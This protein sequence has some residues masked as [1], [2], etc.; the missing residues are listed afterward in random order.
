MNVRHAENRMN[1]LLPRVL[2]IGCATASLAAQ[3]FADMV[4]Q[5][6]SAQ[7]FAKI[8]QLEAGAI[9]TEPNDREESTGLDR[10]VSWDARVWY[11]NESFGSRRGTLEA[12][13]GRDGLFAGFQ[14][15]KLIGD[16]TVTRFE[17][18]GRPWVFYRDAY[19]NDDDQLVPNGLYDG[20]DWEGYIGFGKEAQQ[21]LLIE[22]GPYYRKHEFQRSG[23]TPSPAQF[24]VPN[25]FNAYGLRMYFEQSTLQFD[26]RRGSVREGYV[27]SLCGERE[28][29]DSKGEFGSAAFTTELPSAVWRLR[30]RLD[31]YIPATETICWE[32]FASGGWHDE[33]DRLQNTDGSRP[34]GN[35]W[36]D[37][38]VRLRFDLG[39]S[40]SLAPFV[41]GQ[42]SRTLSLDGFSS[43]KNLFYGGG[44][45]F[46]LHLAD[47]LSLHG[48]YSYLDNENRPS[49]RIDQDLRGEH[50]FYLG[51]VLR[52]GMTRR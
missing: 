30:G 26:R 40:F 9:G 44:A 14:D 2:V 8:L 31:W 10:D 28:W 19:Y 33:K 52:L 38:Q 25:D 27:L 7:P 1:H 29:N 51:M 34:L 49:I 37:V 39:Q 4:E 35:Q 11:R 42:F 13:A 41:Q 23:L 15:G 3:S 18:R 47:P 32:V 43:N 24:T 17:F 22:L 21:G 5:R 20:R 45:E 6:K 48:W 46:Y 36:G 12:Y 16:D 50:M